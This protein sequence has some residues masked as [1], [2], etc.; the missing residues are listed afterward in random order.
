MQIP[1]IPSGDSDPGY[2]RIKDALEAI[3]A[4]D[5][6]LAAP[7]MSAFLRYVVEQTA[8]GNKDRIKAYTVAVDALGKPDTFDPQNDP[9]VRV[10]AGRLRS[11]LTAYNEANPD[12]DVII[13]MNPGSYVP[14]FIIDDMTAPSGT[15]SAGDVSA[16]NA[17]VSEPVEDKLSDRLVAMN[18]GQYTQQPTTTGHP[19]SQESAA[20]Y[21]ASD[22][23]KVNESE[24][25]PDR[26]RSAVDEGIA[27]RTQ[28]P[29]EEARQHRL[30]GQG[31][32]GA[33]AIG[34]TPWWTL[35][36]RFPRITAAFA[37]CLAVASTL[38]VNRHDAEEPGMLAASP[39]TSPSN[40]AG[41]S[42]A[43]RSQ[44]NQIALFVD[45]RDPADSLKSQLNTLLSGVFSE[46]DKIRVYRILRSSQD[47]M[48]RPEDYLL[49]LDVLQM[50]KETQVSVQLLKADTGRIRHSDVLHLSADADKRLSSDEMKRIMELARH[51]ISEDSPFLKDIER[52]DAGRA[53]T[54]SQ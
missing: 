12:A 50:A 40:Q 49:S 48:Y 10:L 44:S 51:L 2:E 9:V 25:R 22:D 21:D 31:L 17:D 8:T 19:G 3:L 27:A 42:A 34:H 14:V 47:Q 53:E 36:A 7:Q 32:M 18:N 52:T 35:P 37:V 4:T 41:T 20:H 45:A 43:T 30:Q 33:N 16:E 26:D 5:K 28:L 29:V 1:P 6:F 38:Y 54:G 11:S 46:S 15:A 39:Q 24:G 23:R 13:E